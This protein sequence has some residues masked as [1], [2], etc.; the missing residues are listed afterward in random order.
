[1]TS[2]MG[3]GVVSH[4][5]RLYADKAHKAFLKGNARRFRQL[6]VLFEHHPS[7]MSAVL[8]Q[9]YA[10]VRG[11][12]PRVYLCDDMRV[13]CLGRQWHTYVD[14]V[15]DLCK[16]GGIVKSRQ[17]VV[18]MVLDRFSF[19]SQPNYRELLSTGISTSL[20]Q[21]LS[22]RELVALVNDYK[23]KHNGE[24]MAIAEALTDCA[25]LDIADLAAIPGKRGIT[26]LPTGN[27]EANFANVSGIALFT[28]YTCV[29]TGVSDLNGP[30]MPIAALMCYVQDPASG[31]WF[32][33][34]DETGGPPANFDLG[35][36]YYTQPANYYP[37]MSVQNYVGFTVGSVGGVP[38]TRPGVEGT[39]LISGHDR[40]NR[41]MIVQ[42][43]AQY[44]TFRALLATLGPLIE[45]D[46][47]P[48]KFL[49][50]VIPDI[51][52]QSG[53]N[54][55]P[56]SCLGTQLT[57]QGTLVFSVLAPTTY[58]VAQF[59][60]GVGGTN[61]STAPL[62]S[63]PPITNIGVPGAVKAVLHGV[64]QSNSAPNAPTTVNFQATMSMVSVYINPLTGAVTTLTFSQNTVFS[65]SAAPS[66]GNVITQDFHIPFQFILPPDTRQINFSVTNLVSVNGWPNIQLNNVFV[67]MEL[68]TYEAR[69]CPA[70][71]VRELDTAAKP[72]LLCSTAFGYY[73]SASDQVRYGKS[74]EWPAGVEFIDD[75]SVA[76]KGAVCYGNG[77]ARQAGTETSGI[78]VPRRNASEKVVAMSTPHSVGTFI[79]PALGAIGSALSSVLPSIL[80]TV[81]NIAS[82]IFGG[83]K[84][85]E[86][87]EEARPSAGNNILQMISAARGPIIKMIEPELRR[88]VRD[89]IQHE[90][91]MGGGG[92]NPFQHEET[93]LRRARGGAAP[94]KAICPPPSEK[95][96]KKGVKTCLLPATQDLPEWVEVSGDLVYVP[97]RGR[98]ASRPP[99]SRQ[100]SFQTENPYSVLAD[101][102]SCHLG[103]STGL[104]DPEPFFTMCSIS[105]GPN[106]PSGLYVVYAGANSLGL[107]TPGSSDTFRFQVENWYGDLPSSGFEYTV[108]TDHP[109]FQFSS[110]M[111]GGVPFG[112]S[113][114]MHV[115]HWYGK[116][117]K[118]SSVSTSLVP[119]DFP[120]DV[121]VLKGGVNA[122]RHLYGRFWEVRVGGLWHC[123]QADPPI[124]RCPTHGARCSPVPDPS[125][126][127]DPVFSVSTA[128]VERSEGC[129]PGEVTE[130]CTGS[131][132]HLFMFKPDGKDVSKPFL[133]AKCCL[134]NHC[135]PGISTSLRLWND[136]P[137][138]TRITGM[139]LIEPQ[140]GP[141]S[142]NSSADIQSANRR[143]VNNS[144]RHNFVRDK[145]DPFQ[146]R[147]NDNMSLITSGSG[148]HA[149]ND[150]EIL[151]PA[152]IFAKY[153]SGGAYT[154][155][156]VGK[157]PEQTCLFTIFPHHAPVRIRGDGLDGRVDVVHNYQCLSHDLD[158]NAAFLDVRLWASLKP[159]QQK[160]FRDLFAEYDPPAAMYVS[161][162]S[163]YDTG[164]FLEPAHGGS[165]F[166]ACWLAF[167]GRSLPYPDVVTGSFLRNE[168]GQVMEVGEYYEKRDGLKILRNFGPLWFPTREVDW[169]LVPVN[170]IYFPGKCPNPD[171]LYA[172]VEGSSFIASRKMDSM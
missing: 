21:N 77:T 18:K 142:R 32:P 40:A 136:A 130:I 104:A 81:A 170:G 96:K 165:L 171:Q 156:G 2:V 27:F 69:S 23:E 153:S 71:V 169:R 12:Q 30:Y 54:I 90:I 134:G 107:Q 28:G 116:T 146:L 36:V 41:A 65:L 37:R 45:S 167:S 66:D 35:R 88:I 24:M 43:A 83:G 13:H 10:M 76:Y 56:F 11:L 138:R 72:T 158:R 121:S 140:F 111:N 118:P 59:C 31:T 137:R 133:T 168:K 22:K 91:G 78:I 29:P 86:S 93:S 139:G 97:M 87:R 129:E 68:E 135:K 75:I 15:E 159:Y 112:L 1:M 4:N 145:T 79:F 164:D 47:V 109:V 102:E 123:F 60:W 141:L 49:V 51:V 55:A 89:E 33:C 85:E 53:A 148:A 14:F 110:V 82:G 17:E 63:I 20:S 48:Q 157:T 163:S 99:I 46:L 132:D 61:P 147:S 42:S 108:K 151:S 119:R 64:V 62:A 113:N 57:S 150:C 114:P 154:G 131:G 166:A 9:L 124:S 155:V 162:L 115:R 19:L 105:R 106:L 149:A 7:G 73:M 160:A 44:D 101:I 128:L 16:F 95:K 144:H 122:V 143:Y 74:K 98:V 127:D 84:K 126:I 38:I 34:D 58:L 8:R 152:E 52:L 100:Q 117:P 161:S 26:Y 6:C 25:P 50:Q 103:V 94:A 120:L 80:P 70:F 39:C 92:N 67:T 5:Y 3:A 172:R 125:L